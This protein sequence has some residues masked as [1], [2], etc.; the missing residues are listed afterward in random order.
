MSN[1]NALLNDAASWR[2][3]NQW[4]AV[5]ATPSVGSQNQLFANFGSLS[6]SKESETD[7]NDV[8]TRITEQFAMD[9]FSEL[10]ADLTEGPAR[11]SKTSQGKRD[12]SRKPIM[13]QKAP[14]VT[15]YNPKRTSRFISGINT[16]NR[17]RNL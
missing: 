4:R 2:E 8:V 10:K 17:D 15:P 6:E 1:Q 11:S 13:P 9:V 16:P 5:F 12:I 14:V 3:S 7:L